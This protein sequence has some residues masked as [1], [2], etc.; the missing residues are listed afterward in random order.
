MSNDISIRPIT[1]T[2]NVVVYDIYIHIS[3][4]LSLSLLINKT[5]ILYL[6]VSLRFHLN[7]TR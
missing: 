4:S 6:R 1:E 7:V 3:L 2:M 5:F